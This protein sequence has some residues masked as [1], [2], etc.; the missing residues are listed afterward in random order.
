MRAGPAVKEVHLTQGQ[1]KWTC[2]LLPLP[3][4]NDMVP[5]ADAADA[6]VSVSLFPV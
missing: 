5:D 4:L 3:G 2:D 1:G 6:Q